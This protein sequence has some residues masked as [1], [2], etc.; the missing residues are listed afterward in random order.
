MALEVSSMVLSLTY[1]L[2][3]LKSD[4]KT[5]SS[6]RY[7]FIFRRYTYPFWRHLLT[8]VLFETIEFAQAATLLSSISSTQQSIHR[9]RGDSGID[10]SHL[11]RPGEDRNIPSLKTQWRLPIPHG[12]THLPQPQHFKALPSSD[13]SFGTAQI[14]EPPRQTSSVND[15][16]TESSHQG[17]FSRCRHSQ[18]ACR[19]H[20]TREN[21]R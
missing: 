17:D 4:A 9:R 15:P 2:I 5:H 3:R 21:Q 11:I 8:S 18:G 13:G 20:P 12:T 14:E 10:L 16:K 7:H 19:S 1:F 6:P